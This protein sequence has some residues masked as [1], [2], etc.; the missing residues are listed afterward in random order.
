MQEVNRLL[1]LYQIIEK[2]LKMIYYIVAILYLTDPY[3]PYM[4][5]NSEHTFLNEKDCKQFVKSESEYFQSTIE[6]DFGHLPIK[7]FSVSCI[8]QDRYEYFRSFY[9]KK[10][11]KI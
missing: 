6:R 8:D 9:D 3:V 5:F 10:G 7:S 2:R 11:T 4:I 1:T